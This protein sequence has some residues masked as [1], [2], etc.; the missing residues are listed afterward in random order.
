MDITSRRNLW[1][2]LKRCLTGKII[3]LST[4]FMEEAS[5][6]GNRVGILT[7]GKIKAEHIGS[8]L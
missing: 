8:P 4:H 6:L 7:E 3:I 1:D 2:I 5:V